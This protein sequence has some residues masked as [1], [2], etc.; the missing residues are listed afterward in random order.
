[1]KNSRICEGFALLGAGLMLV[2]FISLALAL[3][4]WC[5]LK[6]SGISSKQAVAALSRNAYIDSKTVIL[7]WVCLG[8]GMLFGFLAVLGGYRANWLWNWN[9][10]VCCTL[11]FA[12]FPYGLLVASLILLCLLKYKSF[13]IERHAEGVTS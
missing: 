4:H 3:W 13:W 7:G 10:V 9:V 2:R 11:V 5:M 1:M 8:I 12:S 6:Y